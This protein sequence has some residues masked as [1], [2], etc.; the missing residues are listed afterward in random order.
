VSPTT[1]AVAPAAVSPRRA[2]PA[3]IVRPEYVDR[4][5]P[6]PYDGPHVMPPEVI[7]VMRVAGRIAA[8]ALDAVHEAVAPGV[9]ADELDRVGHE[10]LLD[11]GAYPSTLGYKGFPKSVCT[12]VNEVI[13]HGIPDARPLEDGDIVNV[14]IT[15]YLTVDG[16]GAHGDTNRTFLVGD[17]DEESRLLVERT[18]E[19][20]DRGIKAVK[21]GRRINIVGRVIESYARRHGYGVVREFT[22]HGIGT[23]F[24][25]GLIVPH[26]DDA[27]YDTLIEVGMT[28]TIEPMLNLG[29][30]QWEMWDD[31][32]TVVTRDRSR[33]AQFEHTLVVTPT[34]AEVLTNP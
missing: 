25:S 34:G 17:V 24:H 22:G 33:S 2:V 15:A 32:W 18:R 31:D 9:S 30:H 1:T 19:A 21:P 23:A 14:D 6:R 4:P 20:L 5:A 11:A 13:C 26:Y 10:F 8:Q 27:A 3:S 12:S 16:V 7:E 29:T 28:F